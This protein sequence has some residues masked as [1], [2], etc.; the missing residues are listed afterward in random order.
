MA[1]RQRAM[2]CMGCGA[3][4]RPYADACSVCGRKLGDAPSSVRFHAG[5]AFAPS[6]EMAPALPSDTAPHAATALPLPPAYPTNAI[7]PSIGYGDTE[8]LSIPRDPPGRLVLALALVLAA[9]LQAPWVAFDGTH[10]APA[11]FSL[12]MLLVTGLFLAAAASVVYAPF[13]QRAYYAV[14]PLLLGAAAF[15]A[16][17]TLTLMVGPLASPLT[18][19]F[20]A[21]VLAAPEISGSLSNPNATTTLA[22]AADTGLYVFLIGSAALTVAGYQLFVNAV[23]AGAALV[24]R[25]A[26]VPSAVGPAAAAGVRLSDS[27]LSDPMGR[28][29]AASNPA[30]AATADQTATAA[31][32]S[33]ALRPAV[34]LPGAEGWTRT[35]DMPA[36]GRNAP[37]SRSL[38]GVPR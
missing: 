9:D 8:A 32:P 24:P 3:E 23:A 6:V 25:G 7:A 11:R 27:R 26:L 16:A 34:V 20:V 15:G 5:R 13:R 35:P 33:G 37:S 31:P 30:S 28:A 10:I 29:L 18:A 19:T 17:A 14:Y 12:P 1:E 4:L 2:F 22:L 36:V 38:R 21:H